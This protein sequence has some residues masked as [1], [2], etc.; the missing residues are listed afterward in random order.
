MI[1]APAWCASYIG[2]PFADHGRHR[3]TGVDCYGLLWLIYRDELQ[4]ELPSYEEVYDQIRGEEKTISQHIVEA[5]QHWLR[6]DQPNSFDVVVLRVAGLPL[7]L[8]VVAAP[9]LMIHTIK[10]CDV[11]L[12]EYSGPLWRNR[13][14]GFFCYAKP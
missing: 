4:I 7:H 5:E 3:K 10:G 2:I 13:L 11:H 14:D 8:G 1:A 9:G 12:E 6:V